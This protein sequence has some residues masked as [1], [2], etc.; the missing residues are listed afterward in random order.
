MM[1]ETVAV[2]VV[3][4]VMVVVVVVVVVLVVVV[5]AVTRRAQAAPSRCS[6]QHNNTFA[7]VKSVR[8]LLLILY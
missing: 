6:H 4:V 3:V 8:N 2:A 5:L 7:K 1:I